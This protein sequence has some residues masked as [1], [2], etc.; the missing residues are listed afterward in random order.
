MAVDRTDRARSGWLLHLHLDRNLLDAD[1]HN[2]DHI[3]PALQ[4][5]QEGDR[6]WLTP[7]RYLGQPG[8]FWTLKLVDPMRA[9]VLEQRPPANPTTGTWALVLQSRDGATRLLNRH[10]DYAPNTFPM[11]AWTTIMIAGT[12]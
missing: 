11:R 5:P 6:I 9:L 7:P 8:Q 10:R 3:D 4:H 1:I 2:L 12:L